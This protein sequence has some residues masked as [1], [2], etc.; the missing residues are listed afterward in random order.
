[1]RWLAALLCVMFAAGVAHAHKP[2]DAYVALAVDG[3]HLT[4]RIDIALR[5]LDVALGLD[6]DGDGALTWGEVQAAAPRI[7]AYLD[8][9][10]AIAADDGACPRVAQSGALVDL[11]DG[12]YWAQPFTADCPGGRP[13]TLT[14]RYSVL[15]DLD[16]QHQGLVHL[17]DGAGTPQTLIIRD[18]QPVTATLGETTSFATFVRAGVMHIWSGLDHI[19]FL[20]CL[21]LPAVYASRRDES[22]HDIDRRTGEDAGSACTERGS[23]PRN[24]GW[25]GKPAESLRAVVQEVFE[26]VTAFTLAHSITLAIAAVGL[27]HLPS[28]LIETAIA[29]S[30]A[31]AAANNL[32]RA[33]D[34]RWAV[35][36]SL[37]LLHGFGFASGLVDLGLPSHELV[38]ALLG[39]NLGV[40]VGQAA[41]V[42]V[43]V[44]LLFALRRT[45]VYQ[46]LLWA[47]SGATLLLA[48]VWAYQRAHH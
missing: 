16:P 34:A 42:L 17:D 48:L 26:I 35:A 15:F 5:D 13:R 18:A 40:E 10:L 20:M 27:V 22:P 43:A 47:G 3:A 32:I 14:L 30:V 46:V 4:G 28:R 29:L 37:G 38:G 6:A 45:L 25:G 7:T 9:H 11:S 12:T 1:M 23:P 36:F 19:L 2:S 31:A 41:I 8:T 44:P 21:V 39:F 24:G 33:I